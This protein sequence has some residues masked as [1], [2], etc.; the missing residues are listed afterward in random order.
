MSTEPRT[1]WIDTD[2]TTGSIEDDNFK[3]DCG[4]VFE[5]DPQREDWDIVHVIEHSAYRALEQKLA[6][7]VE[8][9]LRLAN[10]VQGYA[11]GGNIC[12]YLY[13]ADLNGRYDIS[14]SDVVD[15]TREA[16]TLINPDAQK[17]SE[18]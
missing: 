4:N 6:V 13:D 5:S 11:E 18:P 3:M 16:L 14:L 17:A 8:A 1:W 15:L 9:G 10:R 2:C 7:A 12:N